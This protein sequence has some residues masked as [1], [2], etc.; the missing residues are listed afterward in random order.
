MNLNKLFPRLPIRA[1]LGIAFVMLTI[2]PIVLVATL[3]TRTGARHLRAVATRNVEYELDIAK[4]Q[5]ERHL[6]TLDRDVRYLTNQF[7]RPLLESSGPQELESARRSIQDFVEHEPLLLGFKVIDARGRLLLVA[8]AGRPPDDMERAESGGVYY[9]LLARSLGEDQSLYLPI[10]LRGEERG[11]GQLSTVPAIAVVIPVRDSSGELVGAAVGEAFAS[12][13][14]AEL[15]AGVSGSDG[16]TGLVGSDGLFLYHSAYKRDWANLLASRSEIDLDSVLTIAGAAAVQ[17]GLRG[18]QVVNGSRLI[19]YAPLKPNL[20]ATTSLVMYRELPLSVVEAPVRSFVRTVALG[21]MIGLVLVMGMVVLATHQLTRPILELRSGVRRLTEGLSEEPLRVDTNDELEDLAVDFSTMARA[22]A[23]HR[24]E[25]EELVRERTAALQETLADFE[26]ILD[27]S[28]DA[29]IGLDLDNRIRVW[30]RGATHLFG[31]ISEE[32]VG[33]NVDIL[34]P[35]SDRHRREKDV[36]DRGL[37]ERGAIVDLRTTR[38]TKSGEVISVSLT[39][40]V[41]RTE[42]GTPLG[43][44]LIVRDTSQQAKLEEH[45]RRSDRLATVSVLAAGLAH[46]LNNPLAVIAN[47]IEC[48]QQDL[49]ARRKGEDLAHDLEVLS[50][51]TGRV[52]DVVRDVLAFA[53]E[54]S[55]EVGSV[56]LHTVARQMATLLERTYTTGPI[57]L[58]VRCPDS[59]PAVPGNEKALE[60][61]CANLIINAIDATSD[62]GVITVETKLA[63]NGTRLELE[64]RDNGSGVPPGLR[65]KIFEPFFTTK[66]NGGGTGL[67]LALCR[68]IVQQHGGRIW[69]ED[70]AGG[71]SRFRVSLPVARTEQQWAR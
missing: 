29:I 64:V 2:V 71:G 45:L 31:Y 32:A 63:E 23:R 25:L 6:E 37:N 30:N 47:R 27:Y 42:S 57:R 7:V 34:L 12:K 68:Q 18:T 66:T 22:L 9:S 5:T 49:A 67:G 60:I 53:K 35:S 20:N 62:D 15:E 24:H 40:T 56:A 1:K 50:E 28:A 69:V 58:E 17:S 61:V 54:D 14:F 59:L 65:E 13:L 44:S 38:H 46:E 43:Y 70:A 8:R 52:R 16:L 26:G 36:I 11:T 51:H 39:W 33:Q 10:E 4:Q 21:G 3:A 55:H 41:V 48:M 19:S